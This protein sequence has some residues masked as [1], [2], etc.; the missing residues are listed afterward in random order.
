MAADGSIPFDTPLAVLG[1]GMPLGPFEGSPAGRGASCEY[2]PKST[3]L[4]WRNARVLGQDAIATAWF[5]HGM[6]E[7]VSIYL[8]LTGDGGDWSK[9]S[10]AQEMARKSAHDAL[11]ERLFGAPL[12]I[13]PIDLHGDGS[14]LIEPIDPGPEHS[15]HARFTWGEVVSGYDCRAGMAELWVNYAR[16]SE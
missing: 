13:R 1:P 14:R 4:T 8:P 3:R 12:T 15:R 10:H 9:W 6:L 7:R 11:A 2:G 5:A 16:V